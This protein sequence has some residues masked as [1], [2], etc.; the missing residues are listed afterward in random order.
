M[1]AF[2]DTEV[3][4]IETFPS[5][6]IHSN[7]VLDI[8]S[9]YISKR[10][11]QQLINGYEKSEVHLVQKYI[12]SNDRVIEIGAGIGFMGVFL[13]KI[14]KVNNYTGVEAN[15]NLFE[16][17]ERNKKLNN[18]DFCVLNH[19][20]S[21]SNQV[22]QFYLAEDFWSSSMLKRAD[23]DN[24]IQLASITIS[25]LI[26]LV[27]F[28]PTTA[29]IDV[30]GAEIYFDPET[31]KKYFNKVCIEFHH[32]IIGEKKVAEIITDFIRN[33]YI[34]KEYSGTVYYFCL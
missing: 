7:V 16:I 13:T 1:K 26:G 18:V 32:F 5:T 24:G 31:L 10:M 6:V 2:K 30:E 23:T 14:I 12:E 9:G 25:D 28:K 17:I 29:I 22:E 11:K 33:G 20:V 27:N 34:L 15:I 3:K 19:L 21:K 4:H 8:T